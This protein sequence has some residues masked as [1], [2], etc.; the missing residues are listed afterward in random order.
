MALPKGSTS[1]NP[2]LSEYMNSSASERSWSVCGGIFRKATA[3]MPRT[4]QRWFRH[5]LV[6]SEGA[7][8][9]LVLMVE[10]LTEVEHTQKCVWPC[11]PLGW[12]NMLQ[13]T[14]LQR[15]PGQTCM[16]PCEPLGWIN[17]LQPTP[18]HFSSGQT[19]VQ[20]CGPLGW[21]NMLQPTPLQPCPGQTCVRLCE[22][23]PRSQAA[24]PHL[25]VHVPVDPQDGTQ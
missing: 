5:L 6:C 18:L 14:P 20:P 22:A 15:C 25:V 24:S 21:I 17:M 10:D 13:P 1:S 16:R 11:Q 23:L 9:E 19:C 12:V 8:K 2:L 4:E 7:N 3:G